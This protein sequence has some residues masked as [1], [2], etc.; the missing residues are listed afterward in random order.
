HYVPRVSAQLQRQIDA[1]FPTTSAPAIVVYSWPAGEKARAK[2]AAK[3]L[4]SLAT[5]TG[6]AH[7]PYSTA[8]SNDGQAGTL[9][10]ALS[11]LGDDA[12]SRAALKKLRTDLIPRTL[13]RVPG[14]QVAV[15]GD[16]ARDVD[17]TTQMSNAL[18]YVIAFVL[19]FA[20]LILL[21]TFR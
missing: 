3:E 21:V 15:S 20:F 16:A 13:G 8:D 14:I 7:P 2:R 19:V 6:I 11:G 9:A 1:E 12:T 18:P 5:S 4:E 17:F 10:L